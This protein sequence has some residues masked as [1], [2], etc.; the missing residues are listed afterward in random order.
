MLQRFAARRCRCLRAAFTVAK[1]RIVEIDFIADP[2]KL[3]GLS[4]N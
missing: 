4:S 3:R 1:G 2:D